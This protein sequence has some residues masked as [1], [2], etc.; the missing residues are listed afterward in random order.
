[1]WFAWQAVKFSRGDSDGGF[2]RLTCKP[3]DPSME[4]GVNI[5]CENGK[6]DY[7]IVHSQEKDIQIQAR[8]RYRGDLD[9]LYLYSNSENSV[10]N[11]PSE[12]LDIKLF[13]ED[14]NKLCYD[15]LCIRNNQY[16]A[17]G[18]NTV[19]DRLEKQGIYKVVTNPNGGN[20][21]SIITKIEII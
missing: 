21:Y 12:F 9:I 15:V 1:M 18:W 8:G 5:K 10:I 2:V 7:V 16:K 19:K 17:V 13:T 4:T 20:S 14:K 6:I 3:L 11:I